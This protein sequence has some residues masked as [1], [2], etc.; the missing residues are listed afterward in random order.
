MAEEFRDRLSTMEK[1]DGVLI[2]DSMVAQDYHIDIKDSHVL[3]LS[4]A[5]G[6]FGMSGK[7]LPYV[8]KELADVYNTYFSNGDEQVKVTRLKRVVKT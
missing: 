2:I 1:E 4:N 3:L 8:L 6:E 7:V 5:N